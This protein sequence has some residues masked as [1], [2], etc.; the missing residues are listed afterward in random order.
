MTPALTIEYE[1]DFMAATARLK[2]RGRAGF[3]EATQLRE[4]V[5]EAIEASTG[6]RNLVIELDELSR[7]DTASMAVLVEGMVATKDRFPDLFLFGAS[8]SVQRVF[9]LAGLEEALTRCFNCRGELA[10]AMAS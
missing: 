4:A 10:Q 9:K 1:P 8:E 3:R 7:I 6:E 2:L 5:F